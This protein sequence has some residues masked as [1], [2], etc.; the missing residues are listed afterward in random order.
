MFGVLASPA[1]AGVAWGGD[2]AVNG[3]GGTW[4]GFACSDS[5]CDVNLN[6]YGYMRVEVDCKWERDYNSGW[7]LESSTNA[8]FGTFCSHGARDV[9]I[10]LSTRPGTCYFPLTEVVGGCRQFSQRYTS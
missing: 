9:T 3:S 4:S 5:N 7:M 8:D 6:G 2:V 10:S 1:S